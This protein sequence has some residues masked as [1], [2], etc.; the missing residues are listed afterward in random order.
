MKRAWNWWLWAGFASVL[1]GAVGY[2]VLFAWHP[3][4]RDFPWISLLLFAAGAGLLLAGLLRAFGQPQ[5][6]R[7]K[8][9]GPILT[10]LS[11]AVIAIFS[12]GLFYLGGQM[13]PSAAAP[14]VGTKAAA[15]TLPDQHGN[16]TSLADLLATPSGKLKGVALI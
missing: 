8:I 5:L 16:P 9:F 6:Y 2:P 4:T 13:P 3:A 7:G 1:A 12:Y 11:L 15:F 14:Q 10:I